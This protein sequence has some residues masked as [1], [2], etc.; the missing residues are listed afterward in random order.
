MKELI[1]FFFFH[2][3][4]HTKTFILTLFNKYF[5]TKEMKFLPS[6]QEDL[7]I[8]FLLPYPNFYS[9]DSSCSHR[10]PFVKYGKKVST[11][12]EWSSSRI[13]IE[14][15]VVNTFPLDEFKENNDRPS[16]KTRAKIAS[17][18]FQNRDKGRFSI[19]IRSN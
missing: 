4:F 10:N 14:T 18:N 19:Y 13:T 6:L 8:L 12:K 16:R 3:Q 2:K 5:P 15:T 7:T 11:I 17:R 1:I 9:R